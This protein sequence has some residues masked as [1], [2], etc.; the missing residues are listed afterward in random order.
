MPTRQVELAVGFKDGTWQE[1]SVEIPE[2]PHYVLDI[3]DAKFRAKD[4]LESMNISDK[5]IA[6]IH[7]MNVSDPEGGYAEDNWI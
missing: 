1:V 2:D 5:P 4:A 3:A 7:T 6:F